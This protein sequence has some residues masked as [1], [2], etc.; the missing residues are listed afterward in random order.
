MNIITTIADMQSVSSALRKEGKSIA[1]VPTMGYL[2]EGHASLIREASKNHDI[3][4]T[5]I[6]VNPMQFGPQEDFERYP[7]DLERDI[8]IIEASG[9]TYVFM[10][11]VEEMYPSNFQTTISVGNISKPFEGIYR[12]GHF[13]GVAT[14]VA[15]LFGA[16]IPDAAYFGQKDYQQTLVIKQ[17]VK[18]INM[19]IDIHIVPTLREKTGL[20]M[21]SRN[22][23]LSEEEKNSALVL[24]SALNIGLSLIA[25]GMRD[26]ALIEQ[27]M[28]KELSTI[29]EFRIQYC[30]AAKAE[31]LEL[32]AEFAKTDEIVLLIAGF[33]GKTRLID[34][35]LYSRTLE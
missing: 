24:Q 18:D 29:Q 34:N 22:V 23:Y 1:C 2:H 14:V 3:V 20:A 5:T 16:T 27:A 28:I 21:S 32:P 31:T 6:F 10:P 12:P 9:G 19:S 4:I 35:M 17:M 15:K 25:E 7:R 26:R 33:L 11:S 30:H 8:A 13:E